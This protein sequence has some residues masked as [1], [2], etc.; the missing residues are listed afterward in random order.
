[1]DAATG[2]NLYTWAH[3]PWVRAYG[4]SMALS[5]DGK[6]V[7]YGANHTTLKLWDVAKGNELVPDFRGHEA[8]ITSLAFSPNGRTLVSADDDLQIFVWDTATRN[9]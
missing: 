7:A 2:K 9:C 8:E 5:P 3:F 1:M 6:T 4:G